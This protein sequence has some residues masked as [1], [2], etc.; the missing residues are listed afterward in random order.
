FSLE[1]YRFSPGVHYLGGLGPGGALRRLYE[2]LG[3]SDDLEFCE[4]SPDGFDHFLIEGERFDVPKGFARYFA[5]LCARFPPEREG[6]ERYFGTI[7]HI[8]EALLRGGERLSSPLS[9][10]FEAPLLV[11]WGLRTQ[12]ALLDRTIRDPLLH[13]ILSAQSGN[14]GLAPS[15][16]SLP[17]HA[18]MI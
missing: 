10:A 15:R 16:V 6:L 9:L 14:H 7:R 13:A 12:G 11:A 3:L 8:H 18:S 4:M 1:G 2:G 5:R 17:L